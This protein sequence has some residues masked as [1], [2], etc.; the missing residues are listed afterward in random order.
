MGIV[1][2]VRQEIKD[3]IINALQS[4]GIERYIYPFEVMV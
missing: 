2:A 3:E 4:N 1:I